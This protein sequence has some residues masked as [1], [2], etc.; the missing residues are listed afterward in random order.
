MDNNRDSQSLRS[1]RRRN[2]LLS[3]ILGLVCV[4]ALI[5]PMQGR[6]HQP[7]SFEAAAQ[8]DLEKARSAYAETGENADL[9]RLALALCRQAYLEG[10]G[11]DPAE[12]CDCGRE[13][14]RRAKAGALDLETIGDP[15]DTT[16]MLALLRDYGVTPT[17]S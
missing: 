2:K 14:Y 11:F 15:E 12:L 16:A 5:L 3:I 10:E 4:A 13:L 17:E 6:E 8:T 7:Y 1:L 9:Y